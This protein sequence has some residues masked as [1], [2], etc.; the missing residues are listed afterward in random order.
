MSQLHV[1]S[2][3]VEG[4]QHHGDSLF[5]YVLL[6]QDP[7]ASLASAAEWVTSQ[8]SE[9]LAWATKHGAVLLRGFPV[10]RA[11]DFDVLIES[12]GLPN[13]PYEKSLSNAV[14]VNRTPRVFSA[15]E[16]PPDVQIF[17]H[18]EMAQTPLLP[19]LDFFQL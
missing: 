2:V 8:R 4:Q 9:L 13:F 16:A 5:P 17:F 1:E 12:L 10:T 11:E 7:N 6:C 14:R 3:A 19:A 15:N 18:H